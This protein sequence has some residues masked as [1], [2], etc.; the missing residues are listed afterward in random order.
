MFIFVSFH[1]LQRMITETRETQISIP[2]GT[3]VDQVLEAVK[4]RFPKLPLEGE[5]LLITVNDRISTVNQMLKEADKV[6]L[7]PHIGGG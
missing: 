3:R 5:D 2:S 4:K 1:G 7:L 6:A